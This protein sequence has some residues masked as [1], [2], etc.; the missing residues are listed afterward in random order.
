MV[1]CQWDC[2]RIGRRPRRCFPSKRVLYIYCY[3]AHP[4]DK[5]ANRYRSNV[6]ASDLR[7]G[8]PR[9]E[10]EA[11]EER[12][13]REEGRGVLLCSA[14]RGSAR[15]GGWRAPACQL[16]LGWGLRW[17]RHQHSLSTWSDVGFCQA[18]AMRKRTCARTHGAPASV[19]GGLRA[20]SCAC[21]GERRG[22][23]HLLTEGRGAGE[24]RKGG[25]K[26]P[27]RMCEVG[28]SCA[29]VCVD[30][31]EDLRSMRWKC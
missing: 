8:E 18:P 1:A 16:Q 12:K 20:D 7:E 19:C 5:A 14:M 13:G 26:G 24:L 10:R 22:C 21:C 27:E 6:C 9:E 11:E 3:D 4:P 30:V 23:S 17:V 31:T 29:C 15:G 25:R 2:P 28:M